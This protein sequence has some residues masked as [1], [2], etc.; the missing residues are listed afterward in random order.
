M[1]IVK[2]KRDI[3][4]LVGREEVVGRIAHIVIFKNKAV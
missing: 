2:H 1:V 4:L 3:E